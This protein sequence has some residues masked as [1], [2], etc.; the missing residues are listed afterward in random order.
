MDRFINRKRLQQT[1]KR[2]G[3]RV[4]IRN[5]ATDGV[6]DMTTSTIDKLKS[7]LYVLL[8][9]GKGT[10]VM[11]PEYGS[12]LYEIQFEQLSEQDFATVDDE[13][14]EAVG[15]WLPEIRIDQLEIEQIEQSPNTFV[16]SIDFSL[17]NNPEVTDQLTVTVR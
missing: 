16:I 1:S 9:T 17:A 11:L 4:P 2:F 12:P 14:R 13:I 3:V 6:F 5:A 10:R 15:R 8:F 7:Q